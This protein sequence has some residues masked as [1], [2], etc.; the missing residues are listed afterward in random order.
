MCVTFISHCELLLCFQVS[1]SF[2]YL[3][4]ILFLA[5]CALI[6]AGSDKTLKQWDLESSRCIRTLKGHTSPIQCISAV[7]AHRVL[8][9]D[10]SG[11]VLLWEIVTGHQL[12]SVKAHSKAVRCFAVTV[13]GSSFVSGSNDCSLKLWRLEALQKPVLQFR[14]TDSV[15]ACVLSSDG[16]RL[17][18]G[19]DDKSLRVWDMTTGQQLASMQSHTE[20]VTSLALSGSLLVSGS[21]DKTVKLW[22]TGSMQ[23][24]RTLLG[25]SNFVESVAVSSD[26]SQRQLVLSGGGY[27]FGT[28]DCI[29]RV[30]DAASEALLKELKGHS[31]TVWCITV[32]PS[33]RFAASASADGTVC[34]WDLASLSLYV[35]LE[36]HE[37][38]VYSVLF[39]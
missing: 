37:S 13:N 19:S 35:S 8:S 28:K 12:A 3:F 25:H 17:Y 10:G 16:S 18:S 26:G 24:L 11:S 6:S 39:V 22:D 33:G 9:G 2:N 4:N 38:N 34:V 36:A 32:C 27:F 21:C 5:V 29:V 14:C 20:A 23:L 30:W 31:D 7:D 15:N 1:H